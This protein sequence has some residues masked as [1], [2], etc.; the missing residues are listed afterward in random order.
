MEMQIHAA[1]CGNA[2]QRLSDKIGVWTR[3]GSGD[4]EESSQLERTPLAKK[5]QGA[6]GRTEEGAGTKGGDQLSDAGFARLPHPAPP[7]SK[8]Q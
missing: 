2:L 7:T 6:V 1:T 4:S 8:E 3:T 5:Q